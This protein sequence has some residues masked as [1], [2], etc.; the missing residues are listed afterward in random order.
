MHSTHLPIRCGIAI[1]LSCLLA[2]SAAAIDHVTVRRDGKETEV[3]GRV[4]VTAQDGG[5]MLLARDGVLWSVPPEE[6][7]SHTSDATPFRGMSPKE[8]S[9]RCWPNCPGVS[10]FTRPRTT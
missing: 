6:L 7:V 2:Q 4:V 1:V 10:T 8:L 3:A 9:K 5:I